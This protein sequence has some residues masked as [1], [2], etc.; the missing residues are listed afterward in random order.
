MSDYEDFVYDDNDREYDDDDREDSD[1]EYDD[2]EDSGREDSGREESKNNFIDEFK[3]FERAGERNS[4]INDFQISYKK[5]IKNDYEPEEKF[6]LQMHIIL[7]LMNLRASLSDSDIDNIKTYVLRI[8]HIEFKN[9][10]AF[11]GGYFY[12]K[13]KNLDFIY[14]K[15][16][17]YEQE[18]ENKGITTREDIIRYYRLIKSISF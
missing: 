5:K 8:Q 18:N 1:R 3:A 11:I 16:N 9:P 7:G 15:I 12:N 2:R 13:N 10:T 4:L 6:R 17:K 14:N